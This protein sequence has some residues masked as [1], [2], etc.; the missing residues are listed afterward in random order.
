AAYAWVFSELQIEMIRAA[1]HGGMQER[2]LI[3][4]AEYL[5]KEMALRRLISRLTLYPKIVVFSSLFILGKSF[6][7]DWHHPMTP[8]IAKLI[9]GGMGAGA[10]ADYGI[11]EYMNDTVFFLAEILIVVFAIVAF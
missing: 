8:A 2:M 10:F 6:F 7:L 11:W 3:R 4:I 9:A 5:E 1:E